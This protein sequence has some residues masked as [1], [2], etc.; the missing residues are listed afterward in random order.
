MKFAVISD[1][2]LD[3]H[4]KR[5]SSVIDPIISNNED[6]D[7]LIVAGD[8]CEMT[9]KMFG[10]A[11]D[12]YGVLCKHFPLVIVVAGNHEYWRTT[13]DDVHDKMRQLEHKFGNFCFLNNALTSWEGVTFYGGTLWFDNNSMTRYLEKRWADFYWTKGRHDGYTSSADFRGHFPSGEV[14][15]V[16]SHHLPSYQSVPA[17]FIGDEFN[18]YYVNPCE[19]L[20]PRCKVWAHGHTHDRCD[21]KFGDTRIVCNPYGYEKDENYKPLVVEI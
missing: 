10:L 12:F 15:V 13:F 20:F 18:C 6:V 21:Y 5:L 4:L 17:K 7:V 14:D 8:T 3:F 1:V 16:I 9:D 2:H 11:T 19:D